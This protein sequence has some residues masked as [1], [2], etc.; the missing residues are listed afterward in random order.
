MPRILLADDDVGFRVALKIGLERLGYEILEVGVGA[1]VI[2]VT[3]THRP[4]AVILE[5]ELPDMT[6]I[7]VCRALKEHLD[8][9]AVPIVILTGSGDR[10]DRSKCFEAGVDS[11]LMK[12]ARLREIGLRLRVLLPRAIARGG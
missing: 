10:D 5:L 2:L 11:F 1:D 8:T 4:D 12:P 9:R 3:R 6:G 7:A